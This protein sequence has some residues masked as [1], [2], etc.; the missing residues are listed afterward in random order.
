MK[1]L[2]KFDYIDG[3]LLTRVFAITLILMNHAISPN[4]YIG[5]PGGML[6]LFFIAGYNLI[7]FSEDKSDQELIAYYIRY[8]SKIII[9]C[10]F[11]VCF[12]FIFT[13]KFEIDEFLF[14]GNWDRKE[15]TSWLPVWYPQM[16]LQSVFLIVCLFWLVKPARFIKRNLLLFSAI[17]FTISIL[18]YP[19]T[20]LFQQLGIADTEARIPFS[21]LW[22]FVQGWLVFAIVARGAFIHKLLSVLLC[23]IVLS[24]FFYVG[25]LK[26]IETFIFITLIGIFIINP[27]FRLPTLLIIGARLIANATFTIFLL[28]MS[29]FYIYKSLNGWPS[30][31]PMYDF[32]M[33]LFSIAACVLLWMISESIKKAYLQTKLQYFDRFTSDE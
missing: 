18:V 7:C 24:M 32:Q 1:T 28:H 13:Q 25:F 20:A 11:I 17:S 19:L 5:V 27:R 10:F 9:P 8:A 21:Y 29:F 30:V 26:E 23:V 15:S 3:Q 12:Y 33:A 22:C 4:A 31:E 6:T 16:L 2:F 14:Y